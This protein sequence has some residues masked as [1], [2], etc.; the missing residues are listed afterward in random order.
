MKHVPPAEGIPSP[1]ATAAVAT[2]TQR[3]PD[4]DHVVAAAL[5]TFMALPELRIAAL[6]AVK[7][8][9]IV[10]ECSRRCITFEAKDLSDDDLK[11]E[12]NNRNF[13]KDESD[14]KERI[15][16]V[17]AERANFATELLSMLN[18]YDLNT[19]ADREA[20]HNLCENAEIGHSNVIRAAS[21][22]AFG[23]FAT[24]SADVADLLEEFKRI[25][26]NRVSDVE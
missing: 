21:R 3:L 7:D 10:A 17:I 23:S 4:I 9:E 13:V 1:S 22:V 20:I 12:Y 25:G 11:A 8:D 26:I 15:S 2:P 24:W 5:G 14:L 16:V 18:D 6:G 19:S